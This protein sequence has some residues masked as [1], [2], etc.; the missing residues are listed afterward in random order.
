V[1]AP[2]TLVDF[3]ASSTVYDALRPDQL[4]TLSGG[5]GHAGWFI[6]LN[7]EPY[8]S[9]RNSRAEG[10]AHVMDGRRATAI[11]VANFGGETRD[12]IGVVTDGHL[13]IRREFSGGGERTLHFWLHFVSM[14]VQVGAATSPQAMQSPLRVEWE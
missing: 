2:P 6:H 12:G 11:A 9:S 5:P 13:R 10:W 1:E 4:F 14:P 8:A 3:G 7:G